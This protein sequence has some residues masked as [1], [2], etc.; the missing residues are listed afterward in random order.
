M[1][2]RFDAQIGDLVFVLGTDQV[3]DPASLV[4]GQSGVSDLVIDSGER[5]ND[6]A[7]LDQGLRVFE[8]SN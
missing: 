7:T 5:T 6:G 4:L 8:G 2:W 1:P 3:S